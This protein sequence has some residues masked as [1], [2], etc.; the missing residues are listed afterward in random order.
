MNENQIFY[1]V[2]AYNFYIEMCV[3]DYIKKINTL[4]ISVAFYR[5]HIWA[6]HSELEPKPPSLELAPFHL[7]GVSM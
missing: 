6:A 5:D 7:H 2:Y 1:I 3:Y 4:R